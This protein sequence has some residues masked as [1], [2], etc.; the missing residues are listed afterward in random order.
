[1]GDKKALAKAQQRGMALY[2]GKA[3]CIQCHNGAL[4]SDQK[5]Y[6]PGACRSTEASRTDRSAR[7]R[8]AGSTT[9]RA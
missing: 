7:S 5:F 4:A 6:S 2:N 3:G 9:R 1:M 8:I